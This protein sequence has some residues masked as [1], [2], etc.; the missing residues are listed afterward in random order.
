MF[1][2]INIFVLCFTLAGLI[3]LPGNV[4]AGNITDY[5]LLAQESIHLDK[6]A[7]V[8]SGFVGVN[9]PFA[10]PSF[11]QEV[12]LLVDKKVLLEEGTRLTA[13][14]IFIKRDSVIKGDIYY[15]D[16]FLTQENV[17]TTGDIVILN[18]PPDWP[19]INMPAPPACAPDTTNPLTAAKN[20]RMTM[21]PGRY[22][23]VRLDRKA[24]VILP[25]GEYHLNSFYADDDARILFSGPATLCVANTFHTRSDV[26]WGPQKDATTLSGADIQVYVN[27]TD[28]LEDDGERHAREDYKKDPERNAVAKIG[29]KN[30]F[31]G[32]V[33]A[34][35][36]TL[37]IEKA[38]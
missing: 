3:S 30:I 28:L 14:S 31:F 2:K 20:S 8:L 5:S 29:K 7:T 21:P 35:N 13:P 23:D 6:K 4:L 19:L 24:T 10:I 38:T 26:F 16:R 25:G 17:T 27:G 37:E 12:Q 33:V 34:L 32:Q 11:K 22:G 1:K 18:A 15:K 9:D 36:G